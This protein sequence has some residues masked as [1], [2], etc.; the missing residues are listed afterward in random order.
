MQLPTASSLRSCSSGHTCMLLLGPLSKRW[1]C[2][3]A[4][5]AQPVLLIITDETLIQ[6]WM[7][8]WENTFKEN[9]WSEKKIFFSLLCLSEETCFKQAGI[10]RRH[11]VVFREGLSLVMPY[12]SG[13][14]EEKLLLFLKWGKWSQ[15]MDG[16]RW[17][18]LYFHGRHCTSGNKRVSFW[19]ILSR[20]KAGGL[21]HT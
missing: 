14:Y 7:E 11:H 1:W 2:G 8:S 12:L 5:L 15:L 19:N 3:A 16:L 10:F 20:W 17:D 4:G 9:L 21:S 13:H 6:N 18:G